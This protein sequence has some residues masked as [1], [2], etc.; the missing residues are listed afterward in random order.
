MFSSM[1]MRQPPTSTF[2]AKPGY[3]S[4][5]NTVQGEGST[6]FLQSPWSPDEK[7][8]KYSHLLHRLNAYSVDIDSTCPLTS[9]IRRRK[10]H[11]YT[12]PIQKVVAQYHSEMTGKKS[13]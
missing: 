5:F 9:L 2:K 3:S 8:K 1:V 10:N 4:A 12:S 7:E 6:L 13:L 11:L